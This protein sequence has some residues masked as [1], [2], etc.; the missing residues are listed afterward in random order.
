[1]NAPETLSE[2]LG[3]AQTLWGA[4][5]E[6]LAAEHGAQFAVDPVRNK[7]RIG[8]LLEAALGATSGSSAAPDFPHL[9]VELKSVPVDP[10]GVPYESTF[11]STIDLETVDEASWETSVVKQK[12]SCV[13]FVPIVARERRTPFLER[14]VGRAVLWR[15]TE[16]DTSVLREDFEE[17]VGRLAVGG[18]EAL[19]ARVGQWL[20]ARPKARDGS[21]RTRS[22]AKDGG[23][24]MVNPKGF[25]LR[26]MAVA[27]WLKR[28]ETASV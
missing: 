26:R 13:L 16:R 8:T 14:V 27:A 24:E 20:Q 11:V 5:I 1:M 22:I 17:I 10:E 6:A 7:G 3:R 23:W 12:L 15:P 19:S 21:E 2:L 25:Y 9:G 28:S 4:S 18:A